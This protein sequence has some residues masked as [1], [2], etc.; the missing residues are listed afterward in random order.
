MPREGLLP[1]L[2]T[3]AASKGH[4]GAAKACC[5]R[6]LSSEARPEMPISLSLDLTTIAEETLLLSRIDR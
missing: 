1:M 3:N 6:I 2:T 5:C 4:N